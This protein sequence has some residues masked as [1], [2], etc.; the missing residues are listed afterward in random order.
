MVDNTKFMMDSKAPNIYIY[1]HLQNRWWLRDPHHVKPED[2]F[3]GQFQILAMLFG[4][5][6]YEVLVDSIITWMIFGVTQ[7][8]KVNKAAFNL[9]YT[10]SFQYRE[11]E[12]A[13]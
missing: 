12:N 11:E 3:Q 5:C 8:P 9:F 1:T 4:I 2:W 13:F 10:G 6:S 7:Q